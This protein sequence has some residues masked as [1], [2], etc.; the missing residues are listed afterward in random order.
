VR[1]VGKAL[2]LELAQVDRLAKSLAWWDS[3][4]AIPQ[5]LREAGFDP[6]SAVMIHLVELVTTLIGFPTSSF[7]AC[8]RLCN[9]TRPAR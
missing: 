5:R 6:D 4:H 7:A 1:D 3:R 8:R 9:F 2:G